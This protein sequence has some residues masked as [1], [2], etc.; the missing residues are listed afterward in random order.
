MTILAF[1]CFLICSRLHSLQCYSPNT[2]SALDTV[3]QTPDPLAPVPQRET[4]EQGDTH[5]KRDVIFT[6]YAVKPTK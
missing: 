3:T 1:L 5:S 4:T 2:V 6:T